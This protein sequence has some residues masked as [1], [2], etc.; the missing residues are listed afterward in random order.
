MSSAVFNVANGGIL[1]KITFAGI[2]SHRLRH[3]LSVP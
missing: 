2:I 3:K 1:S